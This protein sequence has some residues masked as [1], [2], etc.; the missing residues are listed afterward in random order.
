SSSRRLPD[1]PHRSASH[2][3]TWLRVH[4]SPACSCHCTQAFFERPHDCPARRCWRQPASTAK[5]HE[6]STGGYLSHTATVY[7]GGFCHEQQIDTHARLAGPL[8]RAR[9][10]QATLRQGLRGRP[11]PERL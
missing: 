6:T 5:A 7:R 9:S 11:F 10:D 3:A 1:S 8:T 4:L 2:D